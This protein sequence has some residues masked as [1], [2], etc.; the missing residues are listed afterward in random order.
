MPRPDRSHCAWAAHKT[1]TSFG[2][3]FQGLAV[4]RYNDATTLTKHCIS[5]LIFTGKKDVTQR[6]LEFTCQFQSHLANTLGNVG[7]GR[8][9]IWPGID[10]FGVLGQGL[11]LAEGRSGQIH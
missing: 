8:I 3:P 1:L 5:A 11:Q 4:R 2:R 6:C 10:W 7:K 9:L